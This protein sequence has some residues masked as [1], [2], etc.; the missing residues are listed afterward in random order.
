LQAAVE[1][2]SAYGPVLVEEFLPG[3]EYTAGIVGGEVLGV[4]EVVP[5]QPAR[6]F[7]YSLDVKRDYA[8]LVDYRLVSAPD[9]EELAL[10][11]WRALV[12]RDVARV[13]VR[14]DRGGVA[15]FV[16]VNPLPGVHPLNSDL[17]IIARLKGLSHEELIGRV[18]RTAEARWSA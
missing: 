5:R 4:M 17:V 18:L 7:I 6:D 8:N 13:D 2:L 12:L 15:C 11:V 14:R 3:Q 9:V 1:R 10:A 16:E